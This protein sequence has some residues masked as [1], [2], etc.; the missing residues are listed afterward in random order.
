MA[1]S[2]YLATLSNKESYLK[3]FTK[4]SDKKFQ[5]PIENLHDTI[6]KTE[7]LKT[8][9]LTSVFLI[10]KALSNQFDESTK[11]YMIFLIHS[12]ESKKLISLNTSNNKYGN[13]SIKSFIPTSMANE[14]AKI[15]NIDLEKFIPTTRLS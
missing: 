6:K 12:L 9:L 10:Y 7:K 11:L 13:F 2:V 15:H 3:L 14:I 8:I 1:L 5:R 4:L